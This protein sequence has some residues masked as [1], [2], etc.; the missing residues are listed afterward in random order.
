MTINITPDRIIKEVQKEFN[1]EF[2]FLRI[3]FFR[4]GH[5]YGRYFHREPVLS[6]ELKVGAHRDLEKKNPFGITATMT[7]KELE[8]KCEDELGLSI[9]V[10]RKS[11]N[12]WL[13]TTMTDNWTL[14]QQNENG[15]QISQ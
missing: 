15:R 11:G 12:L 8:R 10:Y 6:K 3:E 2:P 4:K 7:V 1:E 14:E 13:E 9:Q 5:R